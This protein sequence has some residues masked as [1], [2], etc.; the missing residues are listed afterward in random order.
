MPLVL[1]NDYY[2]CVKNLLFD[3]EGATA[4]EYGLLAAVIALVV[5]GAQTGLGNAVFAMYTTTVA[6]VLAAMGS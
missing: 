2:S 4:V 5:I 1:L 6:R 3:E